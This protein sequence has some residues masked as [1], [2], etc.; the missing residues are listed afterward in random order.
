MA[1]GTNRYCWNDQNVVL[2][3]FTLSIFLDLALFSLSIYSITL[4]LNWVQENA[5]RCGSLFF[6]IPIPPI[7]THLLSCLWM[8]WNNFSSLL[9]VAL[10]VDHCACKKWQNDNSQNPFCDRI[11]AIFRHF[12]CDIYK[13]HITCVENL[14]LHLPRLILCIYFAS[15]STQP[16]S[17]SSHPLILTYFPFNLFRRNTKTCRKYIS[18]SSSFCSFL[19][20][21]SFWAKKKKKQPHRIVISS[22]GREER[23]KANHIRLNDLS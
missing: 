13:K 20:S 1:N 18:S 3:P 12:V 14:S 2:F 8:Y 4:A 10:F 9:G 21:A 23:V 7:E 6:R 17:S 16:L 5:V 15:L 11:N 22:N 19:K